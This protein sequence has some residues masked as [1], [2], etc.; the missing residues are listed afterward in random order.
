MA[1]SDLGQFY[2]YHCASTSSS[3]TWGTWYWPPLKSSIEEPGVVLCW[4][5]KQTGTLY[6]VLVGIQLWLIIIIAYKLLGL[7]TSFLPSSAFPRSV[8]QVCPLP[9]LWADEQAKKALDS[10]FKIRLVCP[11]V[12]VSNKL[13]IYLCYKNYG[14]GSSLAIDVYK[15][16]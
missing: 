6:I 3:V 9:S 13:M 8:R 2:F 5:I 10:M 15:A 1:L 16:L 4:Y 12:W 7:A 11:A 14:I